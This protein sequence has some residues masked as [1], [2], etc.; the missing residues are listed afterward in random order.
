MQ[1]SCIVIQFIGQY[2][3]RWVGLIKKN[4]IKFTCNTSHGE[5]KTHTFCVGMVFDDNKVEI[6][7]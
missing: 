7:G 4:K 2:I 5:D 6:M 3:R 1:N